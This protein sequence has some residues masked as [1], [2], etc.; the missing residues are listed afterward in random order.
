MKEKSA[1]RLAAFQSHKHASTFI[2]QG[3]HTSGSLCSQC[4]PLESSTAT[5]FQ[6][7]RCRF[8]CHL[9]R[10]SQPKRKLLP[11]APPHCTPGYSITR[12]IFSRAQITTSADGPHSSSPKPQSARAGQNEEKTECKRDK[13]ANGGE[14]LK[15]LWASAQGPRCGEFIPP[16]THAGHSPES[17]PLPHSGSHLVPLSCL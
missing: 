9:L 14:E 13:V 16:S 4:S 7:F 11:P 8:V 1:N 2:L 5:S 6:L 17:H 15:D 12:F 10:V 3:L